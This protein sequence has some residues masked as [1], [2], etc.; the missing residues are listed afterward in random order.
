MDFKNIYYLQIVYFGTF[1]GVAQKVGP[2][3]YMK[4]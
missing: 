2:V 1:R 4:M 3:L